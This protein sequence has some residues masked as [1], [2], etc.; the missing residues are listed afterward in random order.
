MSRWLAAVAALTVVVAL[1]AAPLAGAD[2]GSAKSGGQAKGKA[3]FNLVGMVVSA[4]G[5]AEGE[6]GVLTVKVKSGTKSVRAYRNEE[7]TMT[8]DPKAKIRVVT[9]DGCRAASL[10]DVSADVKVKVRGHIDRSD[11]DNPRFV[12]DFIKANVTAV[13]P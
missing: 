12:A 7:L 6:G 13:T 8:V 9:E 11:K 1:A 3:K 10:A 2:K 4:A 5:A